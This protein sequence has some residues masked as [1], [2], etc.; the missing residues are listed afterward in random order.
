MV[1][2]PPKRWLAIGCCWGLAQ[3]GRGLPRQVESAIS[4]CSWIF[5]ARRGGLS[6][7]QEV[8]KWCRLNRECRGALVIPRGVRREMAVAAAL[9]LLVEQ[10][11]DAPWFP[12]AI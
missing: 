6:T 1:V 9:V 7:F 11:L 3:R 12:A 2:A 10:R 8:Y 5:M 4:L